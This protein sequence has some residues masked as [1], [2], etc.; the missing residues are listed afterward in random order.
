[1][2]IVEIAMACVLAAAAPACERP[3]AADGAP[4]P[5]EVRE[6]RELP[7]LADPASLPVVDATL[8]TPPNAAPP[9]GRREAARV[10]VRLE[11]R[12]LVSELADGAQYTFWTFGGTVPGPMIRV[13]QG[14][15]VEV[16]LMNH[17]DNA[18]PHNIDLHAVTGP[19]GGATSTFTAP[20]HQT[21]FTFRALNPGLYV[22]HCA[23]APVGMHVANGMYGLIAVEPQEGWPPVDREYYVVQSE[24]YTRGDYREPGLQPFDMER[25]IDEN[26]AYVVFNGRDGALVGER[27]LPAQVGQRVRLFV[28]NGGPNLVSSFHVIGEI[29]DAVWPEG[30]TPPLHD[31]QT[32]LVPAGGAAIVDFAVQVPG[33]LI[34]VDHA[35]FRAFN[36]GAIGMLK[37]EGEPAPLVYS[38]QEVDEVYLADAAPR[39]QAA[40]SAA[41]VAGDDLEARVL[42][43]KAVFMGTC[44]TCHMLEGQGM[45]SVF[46]PLAKS[47]FLMADK[48]RSIRIVL[49]GLSGPIEVNGQRYE[50]VMPPFANLTDHEIADVLSFVRNSFGNRGE[51]VAADEVARVR[52]ALPRAAE[53]GHP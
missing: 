51:A 28:G 53:A 34:L 20:G 7:A 29:F 50:N 42:R 39:A 11:V 22:Y 10:I 8:G 32:T 1:M 31:V 2:R 12:E 3:D 9:T 21:R 43:G 45:P 30:G 15:L 49:A 38:G 27:A 47:D 40:L 14:D 18:M 35:L 44:S 24:F 23:T 33:T 13:R 16:H 52:G 5:Q 17:P 25:A 41:R 26:P 36:K 46:P 48:E 37:V 19:G 6:S 4:A